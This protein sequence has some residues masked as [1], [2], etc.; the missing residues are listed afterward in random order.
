MT[1]H[2][3]LASLV[4]VFAM[5]IGA[6]AAY[7]ADATEVVA[8]SLDAWSD[9]IDAIADV[10]ASPTTD[11]AV[12]ARLPP[13]AQVYDETFATEVSIT[14]ASNGWFRIDRATTDNDIVETGPVTVFEGSGWVSGQALGLVLNDSR[15]HRAPSADAPLVATLTGID[16]AGLQNGPD[17]FVVERLVDCRGDWVEVEGTFLGK[18]LRGWTTRT[19]ANQVTTC[20]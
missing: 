11:A 12:I 13:P 6:Q 14:G 8:C 9:G 7:G 1:G 19:C 16:E 18:R 20:P 15:L 17:S 5:A 10:H 3:F 2:G 4:V